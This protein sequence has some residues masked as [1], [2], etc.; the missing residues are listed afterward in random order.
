MPQ[1]IFRV[2]GSRFMYLFLFPVRAVIN[3]FLS[4]Y[5]P[6]R[7]AVKKILE[8]EEKKDKS[9]KNTKTKH[10]AGELLRWILRWYVSGKRFP[11]LCSTVCTFSLDLD[12]TQWVV[13]SGI[14]F[15]TYMAVEIP[16]VWP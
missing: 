10:L 7:V 1:Q 2:I 14:R 5:V 8:K 6:V 3:L 16:D 13:V 15:Q 4:C 11:T 9:R 12:R